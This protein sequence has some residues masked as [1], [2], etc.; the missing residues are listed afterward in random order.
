MKFLVITMAAAVLNL[1][2]D[3]VHCNPSAS[4]A[5]VT[6]SFHHG[7]PHLPSPPS[8]LLGLPSFAAALARDSAASLVANKQAAQANSAA[9]VAL[10]TA[11]HKQAKIAAVN[12]AA[13][14]A[15]DRAVAESSLAAEAAKAARASEKA[16]S[17][18]VEL[19]KDLAK[20]AA[21]SQAGV[22]D[23]WQA[24]QTSKNVASGQE[25]MAYK[26][27]QVANS[28]SRKQARTLSELDSAQDAVVQAKL[29][30]SKAAAAAG[31]V[32]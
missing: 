15:Q 1:A 7:P 4:K 32:Y 31:S 17:K 19:A 26:A 24:M 8:H 29:A 14:E 16:Y 27:Q 6:R 3:T 13:S 28:L 10:A 21:E 18:A 25:T 22:T 5:R 23:A 30:A 20:L 9:Q 12:K 2:V 11:A